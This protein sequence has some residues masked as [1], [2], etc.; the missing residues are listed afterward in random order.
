M[1]NLASNQNYVD[2][3]PI[4][5]TIT[6]DPTPGANILVSSFSAPISLT[7]QDGNTI[8]VFSTD[9]SLAFQ[10]FDYVVEWCFI[11]NPDE[12]LSDT[13]TIT[14]LDI[15]CTLVEPEVAEQSEPFDLDCGQFQEPE[16]FFGCDDPIT[17]GWL[18]DL[19][20]VI[21]YD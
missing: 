3:C 20:T 5:R 13:G 4:E 16:E 15:D 18:N 2:S 9:D 17:V 21:I 1:S 11:N 19:S 8:E 6:Y 10:S 12:C 14:Y 7:E